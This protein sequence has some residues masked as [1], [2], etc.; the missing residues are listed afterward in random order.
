MIKGRQ[1]SRIER[2]NT[3]IKTA[4]KLPVHIACI[5]FL[6]DE[7]FGYLARAAGCF[8]VNTI[9]IIGAM[10]NRRVAKK[11]SGSLVDYL[12]IKTWKNPSEFLENVR[13]NKGKIIAAE[14]CDNSSSFNDYSF[15]FSYQN[16]IFVGH[17]TYGVPAE[18]QH[19]SELVYIPMPG[20]GY[21][22]NT[23]QVANIML[24]EAAKQYENI[25]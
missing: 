4:K 3:K 25:T 20:I 11:L 9:N 18:I 10:P 24:Y 8:G 5:N 12:D 14:L 16:Y 13:Q 17:E 21:C 19:S 22:L 6:F 2:Y 7:N 23:S 1:K 15:D